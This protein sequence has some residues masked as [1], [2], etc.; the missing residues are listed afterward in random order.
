MEENQSPQFNKDEDEEFYEKIE[1]PKYVD[2]TV[3][4]LPLPDDR[5][6]FCLR[7]G[8][9]QKHEEDMEPDALY[10]SF[11]LRVMAARS[12]NLKLKEALCSRALW[13]NTK[14]PQSAPAKSSKD[15]ISR[16]TVI[17]LASQKMADN[18]LKVHPIS[19]LNSAS[20]V[21]AKQSSVAA[22]ALTTPRYKKCLQ[23]PDP[24]HSA[25][26]PKTAVSLTK[27]RAVSKALI[28]DTPKKND[29]VKTSLHS[30][31]PNTELCAQM[32]KLEITSQQK[33]GRS[34]IVSS[35]YNTGNTNSKVLASDPSKAHSRAKK[36]KSK[37][38]VSLVSQGS[39]DGHVANSSKCLKSKTKAKLSR[40]SQSTPQEY[41]D[42]DTSDM[43][44][45]GKPRDGSSKVCSVS[46]SSRNNEEPGHDKPLIIAEA[47]KN[48]GTTPT[49]DET[50]L[51]GEN[52]LAS[53]SNVTA[54]LPN[55]EETLEKKYPP[56]I[57]ASKAE[58]TNQDRRE[59][60]E[61]VGLNYEERKDLES[62]NPKHPTANGTAIENFA[63]ESNDKENALAPNDN[64]ENKID[65]SH[66]KSK[67][68]SKHEAHNQSQK[69]IRE[70]GRRDCSAAA[71]AAQKYKKTKP[72]NPMPFR[73]RTDERGILREANLDGRLH[74]L[75]PFKENTT[76][77]RL[78]TRSWQSR[79]LMGPQQ[80]ERSHKGNQIESEKIVQKQQLKNLET[81][82]C[83]AETKVVASTIQR[84]QKKSMTQL[85]DA[86]ERAGRKPESGSKK[87]KSPFLRQQ[88]VKPQ[89]KVP[90]SKATVSLPSS[91]QMS[92]IKETVS[93]ISQPK[94]VLEPTDNGTTNTIR[95]ATAIRSCSR[96][97][98]PATIPKEPHLTVFM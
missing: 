8:C 89:R 5:S 92:K 65:N 25:Q 32:K 42:D 56:E 1:A 44:I 54:L 59:H 75:A 43:K 23:S 19:K 22:K 41:I 70:L 53:S 87:T 88:L 62:D 33:Q 86:N 35:R 64:R 2:F 20:N 63:M 10:K 49:Q 95:K 93:G 18:K 40:C 58:D 39:K 24:F 3:P 47:S 27:N 76:V 45:K 15:R 26:N 94:E 17:T 37:D 73:L 36:F 77:K 30:H 12:P 50:A 61:D 9:D 60:G 28:F 51:T 68:L 29:R 31:T 11:V 79:H 82:K 48:L 46:S 34:R 38:E 91:S 13:A 80:T 55:F 21:K 74:L 6:W 67:I 81:S 57:Q 14:C 96:G 7:V 83:E 69:L 97:K 84:R 71:I 98:R 90:V 72:T 85:E 52:P 4:V 16:L 78:P 66:S